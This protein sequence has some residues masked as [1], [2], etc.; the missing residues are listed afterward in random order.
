MKPF[1]III[2]LIFA[3]QSFAQR[4][5]ND[6]ITL[7]Y[8]FNKDILTNDQALSLMQK[9]NRWSS[10]TQD[11]VTFYISGYTDS[12]GS[13]EYNMKLSIRR[14]LNTKEIL[15]QNLPPIN[16]KIE[17]AGYGEQF[18]NLNTDSLNRKVT[19]S[20]I[21]NI[22]DSLRPTVNTSMAVD[23][24][25]PLNNIQFVEDQDYLTGEAQAAM[26]GYANMLKRLK[27]DHMEVIGYYNL[28]GKPLQPN[29]PRYILSEKRA[30]V[31][32]SY[33]IESG[34]DSLKISFKGAG[35]SRMVV[36]NAIT[37]DDMRKNIRVEVIL[38]KF[39]SDK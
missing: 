36:E 18:A 16:A 5:V 11:T 10:A 13:E 14:A 3:N 25:I 22:A 37:V 20:T 28:Y 34:L 32:S 7:Y 38:Y 8:D 21:Y 15:L 30:R 1:S 9:I 29:D 6:S 4:I 33:F 31:V 12:A 39:R 27:Y 19:I 35:N 17:T 23:A 24:I 26:P 2:F